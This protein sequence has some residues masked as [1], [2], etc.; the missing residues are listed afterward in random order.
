VTAVAEPEV[1]TETECNRCGDCCTDIYLSSTKVALRQ[2]IRDNPDQP[3]LSARF[4]LA[5]WHRSGTAVGD[6][7]GH[8]R[9]S[10]DRFDPDTRLCTA[11]DDRPPVCSGYPW[12]GRDPAEVAK[13]VSVVSRLPPRCAFFAD[14]PADQRP[15]GWVPLT[16]GVKP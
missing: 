2:I 14:V 6:P 4:V 8:V 13:E 5:H 10:C 16:L 15:D 1:V 9:W 3:S 7:K 12:Y 11:H